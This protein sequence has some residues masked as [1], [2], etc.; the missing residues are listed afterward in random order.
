MGR[1]ERSA[2]TVTRSPLIAGYTGL[3]LPTVVPRLAE[4]SAF[5][6]ATSAIRVLLPRP[7]CAER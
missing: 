1:L 4:W 6:A 5:L 3:L 7:E 2:H